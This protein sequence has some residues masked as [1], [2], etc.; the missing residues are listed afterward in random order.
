MHV[1]CLASLT[2]KHRTLWLLQFQE[3]I[4]MAIVTPLHHM[5]NTIV[6]WLSSWTLLSK[7]RI[8]H[9]SSLP[10]QVG[11]LVSSTVM[12]HRWV[13]LF[14]PQ[15]LL[16]VTQSVSSNIQFPTFSQG[17]TR[18]AWRFQDPYP[19]MVPYAPK[20][21]SLSPLTNLLISQS[22]DLLRRWGN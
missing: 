10:T 8:G 17:N 22:Q 11:L 2:P 6:A 4:R 18:Q 9:S 7:S 1:Q 15:P 14:R 19:S 3:C 12:C 20:R 16:Q 5:Q 21:Q 13:S